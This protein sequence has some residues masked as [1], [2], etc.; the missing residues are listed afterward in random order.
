[1]NSIWVNVGNIYLCKLKVWLTN[2]YLKIDYLMKLTLKQI[3]EYYL[4][5]ETIDICVIF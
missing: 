3:K 1:M 5:S 4:I 2:Y